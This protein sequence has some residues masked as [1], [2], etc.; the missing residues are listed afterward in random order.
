MDNLDWKKGT[1]EVGS[2]NATTAIAIENPERSV[3]SHKLDSVS[4]PTSSSDRRKTLSVIPESV[5]CV[6]HISA[7]DKHKSISL[8]GTVDVKSLETPFDNTAEDMLLIWRLGRQARTSEWLDVPFEGES[9]LPG[10][11]HFAQG[12]YHTTSQAK[13]AK[14]IFLLYPDPQRIPAYREKRWYD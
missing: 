10:F 3:R 11:Q 13:S 8:S 6:C 1:L 9:W 12:C 4:F 14:S 5:A 2:F 7:S